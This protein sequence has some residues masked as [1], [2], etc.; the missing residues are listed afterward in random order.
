MSEITI[1]GNAVEDAELKY[2]PTG[3]AV[4]S[5]RLARTER[6][7]DAQG[8]W[9]DGDTLFI[10]V[11]CWRQLAEHVA[12][13]VTKG[14]RLVVTGKLRTRSWTDKEENVRYVTEVQADDVSVSLKTATVKV[15]KTT[16]EQAP[17]DD[18]EAPF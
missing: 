5:L 9:Q 17:A 3:T 8:Q 11:Q 7:R 15:A 6:F 4:A 10:T 16:R 12:E 2:T 1:T 13:S 14:T 18:T